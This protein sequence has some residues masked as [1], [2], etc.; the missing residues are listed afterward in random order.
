MTHALFPELHYLLLP[1]NKK[2]SESTGL[3]FAILV[4]NDPRQRM[5]VLI[6]CGLQS[7]KQVEV[8]PR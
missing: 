2:E 3:T 1:L 4:I 7:S 6:M 8:M 5:E